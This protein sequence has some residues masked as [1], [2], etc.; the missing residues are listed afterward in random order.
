RLLCRQFGAGLC[1][2]EMISCHGLVYQQRKTLA[3]LTSVPAER[4]VAFQLFGAEPAV[5][6][7]AA[8]MLNPFSPD[9]VDINMGCPVKKVTKKGA[10]A[11]LMA[12]PDMAAEIIRE[13]VKNSDF[14]VTVKFRRGVNH[15]SLTYLDFAKMAED[16]G[17]A[18]LTLHGRTWS[19]GF[20]GKADWNCIAEVKKAVS[21]PVIGNGDVLSHQQAVMRHESSGCDGIMIGR[22]AL[23][24]PWIF[25]GVAR[26][27]FNAEIA[28]GALRHLHLMEQYLSVE[29]LLAAIKNHMGRYFT[30]LPGST[31]IRRRIYQCADFPELRACLESVASTAES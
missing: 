5:M 26:P 18:A 12:A 19:Q 27:Q 24:N 10:G 2:S 11:A 30:G 31:V 16:C 13:V 21:I 20:T 22:G 3:M 14:P 17:A 9:F 29:R 1:F 28:A 4:P 8:D 25:S 6:A 23:G 15:H 7:Q